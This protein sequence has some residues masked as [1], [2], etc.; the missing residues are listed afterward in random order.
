MPMLAERARTR[1]HRRPQQTDA[2]HKPLAPRPA[3]SAKRLSQGG[4][5]K[6][7]DPG[8]MTYMAEL[9]QLRTSDGCEWI[10]HPPVDPYG[11][12]YVR[13]ADVEIR[14]DGVTACTTAT[15]SVEPGG[16]DLAGFLAGLAADWRGWDGERRWQAL[17]RE[18]EVEAWHDGR[19]HVML[20][21][22]VRRPE[23][24]Y[25]DDAWSARVVF[26]V[27]AGEEFATLAKEIISLLQT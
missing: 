2:D 22:T 8:M 20:A 21:V 25:A 7:R 12:G 9:F 26:T 3:P 13:T 16:I 18:M 15:L 14:A 27:E 5:Q 11:D 17:E 23:R 24:A 19:A 10:M 6:A 1:L 4:R